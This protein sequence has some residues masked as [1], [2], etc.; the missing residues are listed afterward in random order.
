MGIKAGRL[1]LSRQFN[2]PE[3]KATR[4]TKI[5]Y[6]N[7][8]A[9]SVRVNRDSIVLFEKKPSIKIMIRMTAVRVIRMIAKRVATLPNNFSA[10]VFPS[11]VSFS[12]STGINADDKAPSPKSL[13]NRW[14]IAKA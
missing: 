8:I 10:D 14:G 1:K 2:R 12:D 7:I 3:N 6:G 5:I 13:R 4:Q 11:L 9:V